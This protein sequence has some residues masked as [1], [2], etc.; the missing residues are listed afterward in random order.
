MFSCKIGG[1]QR[2]SKE[3]QL[4]PS[5]VGKAALAGMV[6][7]AQH[8]MT[9]SRAQVPRS[10]GALAESGY[11]GVPLATRYTVT[12]PLGYGGPNDQVNPITGQLASKYAVPVHERV[13]VPHENGKAKF[14]EDPLNESAAHLLDSV[15]K[16]IRALL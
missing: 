15:G 5:K 9:L 1:I 2:V 16:H 7:H 3:L 14:L 10:T 13:E 8:V 6:E 12:V 11:V 4:A